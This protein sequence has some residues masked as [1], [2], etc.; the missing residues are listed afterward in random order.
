M[1]VDT[2]NSRD[3][4]VQD[5]RLWWEKG[6]PRKATGRRSRLWKPTAT[7]LIFLG[8]PLIVVVALKGSRSGPPKG[9]PLATVDETATVQFSSGATTTAS[10][11]LA[12]FSKESLPSTPVVKKQLAEPGRRGRSVLLQVTAV[13]PGD[14]P[15]DSVASQAKGRHVDLRSAGDA[16]VGSI[17]RCKTSSDSNFVAGRLARSPHLSQ[18]NLVSG[19]RPEPA[20]DVQ[21]AGDEGCS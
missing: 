7:M 8:L 14:C 17:S 11:N 5:F 4:D 19:R 2:D 15:V 6:P 3:L 20:C 1:A 21:T 9:P 12:P 18:L 10:D 13:S 16:A